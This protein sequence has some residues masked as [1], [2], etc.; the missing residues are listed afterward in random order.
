ME[1]MKTTP[2]VLTLDGVDVIRYADLDFESVFPSGLNLRK[3]SLPHVFMLGEAS[4]ASR[5]R[6][7]W[8]WA[9]HLSSSCLN[10][11]MKP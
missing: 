10:R 1:A 8:P 11:K 6:P 5:Y 3:A 4:W 9:F 2:K 7:A